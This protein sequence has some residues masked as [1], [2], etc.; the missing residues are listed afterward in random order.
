M[1]KTTATQSISDEEQSR[2]RVVDGYILGIRGEE[3]LWMVK[4]CYHP[5]KYYIALP[6]YGPRG[7]KFKIIRGSWEI[8]ESH[9]YIIYDYCLG[10]LVPAVPRIVVEKI[11][12]PYEWKPYIG[13]QI[14]NTAV[15]LRET[16]AHYAN[17]PVE[18]IGITGSLLARKYIPGLVPE[19]IDIVVSGIEESIKVYK[20]LQ[21]M[22]SEGVT[23]PIPYNIRPPDSEVLDRKSRI[24]LMRKRVLEGIFEGYHYSIRLIPC[25]HATNCTSKIRVLS[26]WSGVIEIV[27][28]L[29]PYIS[30][31]TYSIKVIATAEHNPKPQ[32]LVSTR[33]RFS[34]IPVGTRLYIEGDLEYN[35]SLGVLQLCPDH[36]ESKVKLL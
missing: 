32:L 23:K 33:L 9:G 12:S 35:E 10:R 36:P 22:R 24:R 16:I 28:Q 29:S 8:A 6:R 17:I 26:Q 27:E 31:Y 25:K 19:D 13:D 2:N 18:E 11:L 4:E 21:K 30:P 7:E 34:E 3:Y 1:K 15:K 5:P 20:A 14:D